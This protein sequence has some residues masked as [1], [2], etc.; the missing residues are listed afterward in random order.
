MERLAAMMMTK[1]MGN[2]NPQDPNS[3]ANIKF[4][5][6]MRAL[7]AAANDRFEPA[8][9]MA[10]ANGNAGN[11]NNGMALQLVNGRL[12]F[13]GVTN[14]AGEYVILVPTQQGLVPGTGNS[15]QGQV[16]GLK[17]TNDGIKG[18]VDWKWIFAVAATVGGMLT[19]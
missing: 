5:I 17:K 18:A 10:S 8:P 12:Q 7:N 1:G 3:L 14:L 16:V 19:W 2:I 13:N 11:A 4:T 6:G 15:Q 9:L